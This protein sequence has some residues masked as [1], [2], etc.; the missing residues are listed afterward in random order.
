MIEEL[1][2]LY[3]SLSEEEKKKFL[4]EK[5]LE[6]KRRKREEIKAIRKECLS[7]LEEM[8]KEGIIQDDL[9]LDE[10]ERRI[11]NLLSPFKYE[12]ENTSEYSDIWLMWDDVA[13]TYW[14]IP[15]GTLLRELKGEFLRKYI[16][17]AGRGKWQ[18]Y[19][20][21]N[22]YGEVKQEIEFYGIAYPAGLG[23]FT[24]VS[25]IP[26]AFMLYED[27]EFIT[28]ARVFIPQD[29]EAWKTSLFLPEKSVLF[30]RYV[31]PAEMSREECY[32]WL[33]EYEKI[34]EL[35]KY[36]PQ[37]RAGEKFLERALPLMKNIDSLEEPFEIKKIIYIVFHKELA[38]C[39]KHDAIADV[40][41]ALLNK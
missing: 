2:K 8:K 25:D 29:E 26:I 40:Y 13:Q 6:L 4:E 35:V 12:Y 11:I 21:Q 27:P 39:M 16:Q 31:R 20:V 41:N 37:L 7:E 18:W 32:A 38:K 19:Y 23:F 34:P 24:I 36:L 3:N 1:N 5:R 15:R 14:E 17:F 9:K 30:E 33:G 28:L 22:V 10:L